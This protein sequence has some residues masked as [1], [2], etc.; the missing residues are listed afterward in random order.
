MTRLLRPAAACPK[1]GQAPRLRIPEA[2]R[3]RYRRESPEQT[4]CTIQCHRCHTIYPIKASAYHRA[5]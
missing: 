2:E 1:C 3:E 5:A 4:V